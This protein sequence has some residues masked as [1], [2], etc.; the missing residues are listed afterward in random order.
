MYSVYNLADF[1]CL[2]KIHRALAVWEQNTSQMMWQQYNLFENRAL[3]PAENRQR[4]LSKDLPCER[5]TV[6]LAFIC[7]CLHL[8]AWTHVAVRENRLYMLYSPD[9]TWYAQA[10]FLQLVKGLKYLCHAAVLA[11]RFVGVFRRPE[12]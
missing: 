8:L 2:C 1:G 11:F 12:P 4:N 6:N 10:Y 5:F 9:Y 7:S 3:G